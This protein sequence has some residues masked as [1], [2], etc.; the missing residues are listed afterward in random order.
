MQYCFQI[1][2]TFVQAIY[3]A[4]LSFDNF[5]RSNN[6]N[7]PHP[8]LAFSVHASDALIFFFLFHLLQA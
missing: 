2:L 5:D 7:I 3:V 1:E 6:I 4:V 8:Q